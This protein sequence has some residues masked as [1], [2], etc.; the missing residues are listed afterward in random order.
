MHALMRT[1]NGLGLLMRLNWDRA[2]SVVTIFLAL[3]AG[4]WFGSL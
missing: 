4:A 1:D 2:L 3:T